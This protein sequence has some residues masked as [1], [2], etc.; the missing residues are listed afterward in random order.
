MKRRFQLGLIITFILAMALSGCG[1]GNSG[2]TPISYTVT[3]NAQG[4]NP[5]PPAQ[6]VNSGDKATEPVPA[7]T[8]EGLTFAGWF[9][10][11]ECTNAWVFSSDTVTSNITLYAQWTVNQYTVTFDSQN[12]STIPHQ[13]VNFGGKAT[14]PASPVKGGATFVGWFKEPE[15]INAW[16]F[17]SD[18]VTGNIT[19]YAKWYSPPAAVAAGGEHTMILRRDGSLW[20]MGRNNYGQLG[21]GT[22]DNKSTPVQV[23][24]GVSAVAAGAGHTMILRS[25]GTLW[26]VGA[27]GNGQ[28]GDNST[29]NRLNPVQVTSPF[30]TGATAVAAGANRTLLLYSGRVYWT[31]TVNDYFGVG[32]PKVLL[33]EAAT[34]FCCGEEHTMILKTDGSLW[35]TGKNNYGQ[36]GDGTTSDQSDPEQV[37]TGVAAVSAGAYHTMIL[38]TDGSLWATGMNNYGQLGDGTTGNKSTP[39]QV[40]T[41]VAAVSA[42]AGHTMILKTDGSLWATGMNS[43]GQ[44][45]DGTTGNKRTPE[46]VMTGVAAVAAGAYH[47]MILKTD[48]TLWAMG[49]N[50]SGQL[51]DGTTSNKRTPVRIQ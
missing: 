47:T 10:E 25:N 1:G 24:T 29:S 13:T 39:V 41:G 37:M 3:F 44:L 48:G 28:L 7:P 18:I 11:A 33:A 38:K 8:K 20:A 30:G 49:M 4:G 17:S 31:G 26:G 27:N 40:M 34:G 42:G 32:Y 50:S 14:E 2:G 5:V 43:S 12:G 23:M 15:Y 35:A 6:S 45:G 16:D 22:T 19:L 21:D 51:G 9:K 36:L 46:Q